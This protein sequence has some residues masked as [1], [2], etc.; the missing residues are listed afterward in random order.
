MQEFPEWQLWDRR[1]LGNMLRELPLHFQRDVLDRTWGPAIRRRFLQVPGQDSFLS[2]DAIQKSREDARDPL[3]DLGVFA[4]RE[5]ER[6]D[7]EKALDRTVGWSPVIVVSGD[8]GSG[9]TRLLIEA[10]TAFTARE[11]GVPVLWLSPG[12]KIDSQAIAELPLV[13]LVVVIDDAHLDADQLRQLVN[14]VRANP[15]TQLVIGARGVGVDS[16]RTVLLSSGFRPNEIVQ[17]QLQPLSRRAARQLVDSVAEDLELPD[18]M[19]EFLLLQ[20]QETPYLPVLT[21]NLFQM[22]ELAGPVALDDSLRQAVMARYEELQVG[23]IRGFSSEELRRVMATISAAGSAMETEPQISALARAS[24]VS[25][26]QFLRIVEVLRTAGIVIGDHGTLRVVPEILADQVLEAEAVVGNTVTSFVADLWQEMGSVFGWELVVRLAA[27]DW[28]LQERGRPSVFGNVWNLIVGE[29]EGANLDGLKAL[30]AR[31]RPLIFTQ[32]R[33]LFDLLELIWKRLDSLDP[34]VL[35]AESPHSATS[36]DDGWWGRSTRHDVWKQLAPLY[37]G[38][39][40]RAH[41][42]L[43]EAANRLWQLARRDTDPANRSSDHPVRVLTEKLTNLVELPDPTFPERVIACMADWRAGADDTH[44]PLFPSKSLV[45]KEGLRTF[46][47]SR[48]EITMQSITVNPEWAHE[49]RAKLRELLR[50]RANEEGPSVAAEI[51][52]IL[53]VAIREPGGLLGRQASPEEL[54]SWASD[55]LESIALLREIAVGTRSAAVRRLISRALGWTSEFGHVNDVRRAAIEVKIDLDERLEDDLAEFLMSGEGFGSAHLRGKS[56]DQAIAA[57]AVEDEVMTRITRRRE[58]STNRGYAALD[59]LWRSNST[60]QFLEAVLAELIDINSTGPQ[61]RATAHRAYAWVVEHHPESTADFAKAVIA[62][63]SSELGPGLDILLSNWRELDRKGFDSFFQH[64]PSSSY[65]QRAFAVA[66][67]HGEWIKDPGIA[68]S[69]RAGLLDGD[70]EARPEF[71][72]AHAK[73]MQDSP[74]EVLPYLLRA[75]LDQSTARAL[76]SVFGFLDGTAWISA[77]DERDTLAVL[78]VCELAGLDDYGAS[79]VFGEAA[80]RRPQIALEHL[81]KSGA[82]VPYSLDSLDEVLS[83]DPQG[84]ADW[85]LERATLPQVLTNRVVQMLLADGLH[86]GL[87]QALLSRASLMS[88]DQLVALSAALHFTSMWV[89]KNPDLARAMLN[90]AKEVDRLDEV[91]NGIRAGITPWSWSTEG[92]RSADLENAL[93]ACRA[94]A[95]QEMNEYLKRAFSNGA[96]EIERRISAVADEEDEE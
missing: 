71:I 95:E 59:A 42:L 63:E 66:A 19:R 51:V 53:R 93:S 13:P 30:T 91:E 6:D 78:A 45:A 96:D 7:I 44:S 8:G 58:S 2:V 79:F 86:G 54:S 56:L 67:A 40:A 17:V 11:P 34:E 50:R 33:R 35:A 69:V 46:M 25:T 57:Y 84:V 72:L 61:T 9:K 65:V 23:G 90:R 48:R 92:G 38:V 28:R 80:K 83:I 26:T 60:E 41:D 73:A 94:A 5:P 20:A 89:T 36:E 64:L 68:D 16:V 85:L 76:V 24:S 29:V 88:G 49:V 52:E 4:G 1:D 81:E 14:F 3:N 43:E 12:M 70:A 22:G 55:D 15:D 77:L 18:G 39:A 10:M 32:P 31:L 47:S 82:S 87:A 74:A 21:L 75:G 37:G 62:R 27:L